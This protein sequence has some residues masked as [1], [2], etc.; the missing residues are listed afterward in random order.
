MYIFE[1][2]AGEGRA[3]NLF[4]L[5]NER[6]HTNDRRFKMLYNP[7]ILFTSRAYQEFN[8]AIKKI[9]LRDTLSKLI[10]EPDIY[11]RSK[12][13]EDMYKT[14]Q[15]FSEI[16]KMD[17]QNLVRDF[18]L[19]PTAEKLLILERKY[20]DSISLFDLNGQKPKRRKTLKA[21]T[22]ASGVAGTTVLDNHSAGLSYETQT[23]T[24]DDMATTTVRSTTAPLKSQLAAQQESESS[25]EDKIMRDTTKRKADTDCQNLEFAK[26]LRTRAQT[27]HSV[28]F[29]SKNVTN[30]G[31]MKKSHRL[32]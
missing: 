32:P 6:S 2:L 26:V 5:E 17:R 9:K 30:I 12:V 16:R 8:C 29:K 13:P 14:L 4:Y 21:L 28:D 20:G 10:A 25:D 18:N 27:S 19:Y 23:A 22:E 3:M 11:L 24:Q 31:Q 1:G 7:D 15:Q